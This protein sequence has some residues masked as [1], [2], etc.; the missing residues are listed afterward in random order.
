MSAASNRLTVD[1]AVAAALI[2]VAL[3]I[4]ARSRSGRHDVAGHALV[5]GPAAQKYG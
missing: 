4:A 2:L 3:V 5:R 1:R